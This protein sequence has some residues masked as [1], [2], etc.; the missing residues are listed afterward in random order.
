MDDNFMSTN[1]FGEGAS[2]FDQIKLVDENG[3]D[4]WLARTLMPHLGYPRWNEFKAA[5][6]RASCSCANTQNDVA[7]HFS[8]LTLKSQ[9]RPSLDYKLSRYACYLVA[10]NGD[11]RKKEI[12]QAQ[13][14]FTVK[15]RE[16]EL[17]PQVSELISELLVTIEQQ[18]QIIQ[19]HSSAIAELQAQVQ[20]LRRDDSNAPPPGWNA[21]VWE[22][23]PP[24]DKRHFR[25]LYRRRKFRPS[26]Q[27]ENEPLILPISTE[28]M[29]QQQREEVE[30]VIG[31][32]TPE[33]KARIEAAKQEMLQK[34][35]DSQDIDGG[36]TDE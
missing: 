9:G 29:K 6:E 27:G 22:Q 31:E 23:L 36:R 19:E 26:N 3:V 13:S 14:Y 25:F 33:E 15:T 1:V 28:E 24:Q 4:Y 2:P 30:A 8:V 10:M 5:I 7:M 20:N 21:E 16:A 11:P 17:A 18:N 12:A 35:W 32:V 34:L